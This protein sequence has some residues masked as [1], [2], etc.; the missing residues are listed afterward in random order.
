MLRQTEKVFQSIIIIEIDRL[1]WHKWMEMFTLIVY[2][3][4]SFQIKAKFLGVLEKNRMKKNHG[5][6]Y[7]GILLGLKIHR[8]PRPSNL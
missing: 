2:G 8:S 6:T 7:Y 3:N 1:L 4:P 5:N